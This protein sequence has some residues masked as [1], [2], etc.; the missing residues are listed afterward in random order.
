MSPPEDKG[1]GS[2]CKSFSFRDNFGAFLFFFYLCEPWR[3]ASDCC[4]ALQEI[5]EHCGDKVMGW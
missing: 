1:K 2:K 5:H 3:E 4:W